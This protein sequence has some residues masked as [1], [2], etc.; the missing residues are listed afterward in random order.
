[1]RVLSETTKLNATAGGQVLMDVD[2][3]NTSDVIDGVTVRV[4]GLDPGQVAC[5]PPMLPLFPD[6]SGK[7]SLRIDIPL[8]FPA[9]RHPLTVEV[10]SSVRAER[11]Q[12]VDVDLVVAPR[13]QLK[14]SLRPAVQRARR[15]SRH[16]VE[17]RNAGNVPL[18]LVLTADDPERSLRNSFSSPS[19]TVEP[20]TTGSVMLTVKAK[21]RFFGSDLDRPLNVRAESVEHDV[22]EDAVAVLRHRPLVPRGVLTVG[23]LMLI[24][25]LWAGAFLLGLTKVF[26]GDAVTKTA[27]ASFFVSSNAAVLQAANT[28]LESLAKS[29]T[30]PAG[31]GGAIA[32]TVTASST[33]APTGR[34]VVTAVRQGRNGPVRV[35]SAASQADGSYVLL[36]LLP[37]RYYVQFTAPGFRDAWYPSVG[38][39]KAAKP[40]DAA[41]QAVTRGIDTNVVG[42]P[43]SIAGH[44][45]PGDAAVRPRTSVTARALLGNPTVKPAAVATTDAQGR[46]VLRGLPAP[47]TYELGFT[48]P[49]YAPTTVIEKVGG[50]QARSEPTVRLS[51]GEGTIAGLVF[52]DA[53]GAPA[54]LGEVT[55]STSQDG[56]TLSTATPTQG[57]VGHFALTGLATPGTYVVTFVKPGFGAFTRV[58]GLTPGQQVDL[59]IR[60]RSGTGAVTGV[61]RDAAHQP[62]GGVAVTVGGSALP[63]QTTT[64]TDGSSQGSYSLSGLPVP[65]AY[66]LTFT[67]PGYAP[68]TLP[69]NLALD[70]PSPP[71]DAVL[72]KGFGRIVGRIADDDTG[73]VVGA[74]ITVSDGLNVHTTIS[75]QGDA[76]HA[77]GSFLVPELPPATYTVTVTGSGKRQQTALVTVVAARDTCQNLR[78]VPT[79]APN[80]DPPPCG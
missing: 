36:G 44:V 58:V 42:L 5:T 24:I 41:P 62:L 70:A 26:S 18:S 25:G 7:V 46:Y 32:G 17:C 1:M 4:I 51:A 77:V 10:L 20:A 8:T 27:P 6:A 34:I 48:T 49:G 74:T 15:R 43:A 21:R 30:L 35:A 50:G 59:R 29:G 33:G 13:P 28:S 75:V 72:A 37:G 52:T 40:V 64:L 22:A 16:L 39:Q 67:L 68:Q 78:S 12:H 76:T 23:I 3:T 45:D 38:T 79:S 57:Q 47:G 66:T 69:L 14:V 11:R 61:V 19:I 80:T 2:V 71:T 53:G 56:R 73:W 65:G 60:L 63:M 54:G 31:V 9:G 55:V